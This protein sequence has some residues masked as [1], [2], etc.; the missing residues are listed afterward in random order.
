MDDCR[1]GIQYLFQTKNPLTFAVSGTGHAGMECAVMNLLER[2]ETFLVVQNGIWGARASALGRRLGLNVQTIVVPEGSAASLDQIREA[3]TQHHPKVLF[4]CHGESSTG[5]V[6]PLKGIADI[7]HQNG[8]LLLVDTVASIGGADFDADE[9]G[10]DCVYTATQKVLNA[11]PGLAPISFSPKAVETIK[12]RKTQCVSF[13]FDALELGN[14]W[15]C[16]GEPRRYHH[17]GIISMVYSLRAALAAI[18][19]EGIENGIRRH[20]E[21]CI[22]FHG[23]LEEAGFGLFVQDKVGLSKKHSLPG[24]IFYSPVQESAARSEGFVLLTEADRKV[25]D[26]TFS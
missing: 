20:K 11:P 6:H 5:V 13:Y 3:I 23:K 1:A 22:Y 14:Y 17:T 8:T 4:V 7:C 9:L 21:N 26:W 12:N 16:F 19:K 15:G 10:I 24:P 18:A 2:D 25:M